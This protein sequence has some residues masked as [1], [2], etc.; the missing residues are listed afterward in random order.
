MRE[1]DIAVAIGIFSRE[2][3]AGI[4]LLGQ[5][6]TGRSY[7]SVEQDVLQVLCGQLAIAIDNAQL[8]T[9]VQNAKIYNDILLQNLTTGVIA[10][11]VDERLTVFNTEAGQIT[12]F[13]TAD[14][15]DQPANWLPAQLYQ[16]LHE[17]LRTGRGFEHREIVLEKEEEALSVRA[18]T[19]I[20][21]G[22][23]GQVL[24]ALMVLTD[25]TALKRPLL[26]TLGLFNR[27]VRELLH[28]YY[29]FDAPFV[30]DDSAFRDAFGG[31]TT[32][33]GDIV[34]RTVDWYRAQATTPEFSTGLAEATTLKV[35]A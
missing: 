12:G 20:F 34:A 19:S 2:H 25:V 1:L 3:L 18:S 10:V 11:G 4:M 8:F 33:W 9:E 26:R 30:V 22:Q 16:A 35:T 31:H 6:V 17:T 15:I 13:K 23:E 21:K 28:T 24:G 7:T 29:Q 5:R 27:N 14:V 32:Q